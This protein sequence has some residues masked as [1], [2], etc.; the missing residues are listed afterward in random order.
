MSFRE[1][2]RQIIS[3]MTSPEYLAAKDE[4]R[5]AFNAPIHEYGEEVCFGR[6]WA[7]K[8]IDRKLRSIITI[9]MLVA[10][11]HPQRLRR[12]LENAVKNGCTPE[13]IQEVLLHAAVYCGLPA[14]NDAFDIAED[15]LKA[16]ELL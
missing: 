2:G 15:V 12:H 3:E 1:M 8:G 9:A 6:V 16:H 5:N 11:N 7:R 10:L 14:A 13:E 4:K